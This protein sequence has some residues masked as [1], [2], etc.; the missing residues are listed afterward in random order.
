M[1]VVSAGPP[2]WRRVF[3]RAERAVGRPLEDVVASRRFS[4][5]LALGLRAEGAL[6]G[7]FERQTRTVLHFWNMPARTDVA[8]L[9]RQ[10]AT[11]TNEVRALAA[12]LDDE[13]ES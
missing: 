1:A 12:R 8:R 7:L 6:R 4:D 2:V 3:D 10:V 11:L 9:N 5:V 13:R